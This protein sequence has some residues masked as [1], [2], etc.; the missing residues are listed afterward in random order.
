MS[1]RID[2]INYSK[3]RVRASA[4]FSDSDPR[5]DA[6]K[7]EDFIQKAATDKPSF[8]DKLRIVEQMRDEAISKLPKL[9]EGRVQIS[10]S[11]AKA[12]NSLL[13]EMIQH[14]VEKQRKGREIT[15]GSDDEKRLAVE[16]ENLF[17][18]RTLGLEALEALFPEGI[19]PSLDFFERLTDLEMRLGWGEV[20][21]RA[22]G[23][24]ILVAVEHLPVDS[25]EALLREMPKIGT[26]EF[27][28]A[29][30]T[31]PVLMDEWEL[32]P[33][34][35]A[36]WFP[37]LVRRIGNDLASGE[38]W[39]ALGIYCER[40][41]PSSLGILD[42]L[43]DAQSE[44]HISVAANILGAVRSLELDERTYA[45]CK[46]LETEF[47]TSAAIPTRSIYNRSWIET[48]FRGKIQK[49]DLE[50]LANRMIAGASDEREQVFGIIC[51]A[52]RSPLVPEDCFSFGLDWLFANAS[53][54]IAPTAKYHIIEFA[55]QLPDTRRKE[56]GE[57][58]LLVQPVLAEHK[59]IWDR[60]ECFLVT[61]LE[62]DL[63]GFSRFSVELAKRNARNWLEALKTP[64]SS[65]WFLS[66]L[67]GKDVGN[68]V[69]QLIL[70]PL[71][72]CRQLGLF[73]FDRLEISSF[74]ATMLD[75]VSESQVLVAF[76]EL[77]RGFV[78]GAAIGR[79]LILLIP[80]IQKAGSDFQQEFYKE[81]VLQ[82]KN[83]PGSCREECERRASEFPILKR[84]IE[85][86]DRYF[87]ALRQARQS[88]ISAMEVSGC[89]QAERLYARQTSNEISKGIEASSVF[90]K[91][92]RKVH[93]IYGKTWS[94]FHDG[95][96]GKSSGLQQFSTSFEIPRLEAIDPEGIEFRRLYASKRIHELS[97]SVES[98]GENW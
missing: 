58:V 41:T 54:A 28:Q 30:G 84:A 67:R 17:A 73:L 79:F 24:L 94:S 26:P 33:E 88:S 66:K 95:K 60:I 48:A 37:A 29:L 50:A 85:E 43:S 61:W 57:L 31:L 71:A 3:Q 40:H 2:K 12:P 90:L 51:Q 18:Q 7:N 62:A 8:A 56:A 6:G 68:I 77:Q 59:G 16:V 63:Q 22:T 64:P 36:E 93:L 98:A 25:G 46:R 13:L 80:Y 42:Y 9:E 21:L 82:L 87:D 38:F 39:K 55:A 97:Q 34:F 10:G 75:T 45:Q 86:V 15:G 65:H 70:S 27:F 52:L 23:L 11:E 74:P 19:S 35:A 69:G 81:L 49:S 76:Y 1:S 91:L 20:S 96:L 78:N 72:Y 83:Y 5:N 89:R 44:E 32:R 92:I 53:G 47:S 4:T 14:T